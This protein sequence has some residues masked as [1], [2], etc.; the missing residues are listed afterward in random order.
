MF[1]SKSGSGG[2]FASRER[3]VATSEQGRRGW[4]RDIH[5]ATAFTLL[6]FDRERFQIGTMKVRLAARRRS[7]YQDENQQYRVSDTK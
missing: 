3:D 2:V 6:Q 7:C 4:V 1:T 5:A